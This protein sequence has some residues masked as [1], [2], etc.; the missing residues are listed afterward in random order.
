[1]WDRLFWIDRHL[2]YP[3]SLTSR[4]K[5]V[6]DKIG[7]K[8]RGFKDSSGKICT[9]R[10]ANWRYHSDSRLYIRFSL[11]QRRVKSETSAS[12]FLSLSFRLTLVRSEDIA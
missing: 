6:E 10:Y 5:R 1:M 12:L 2:S 8:R 11:L 3:V 7:D 4:T 9:K